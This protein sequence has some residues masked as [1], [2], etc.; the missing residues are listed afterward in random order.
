MVDRFAALSGDHSSLHVDA[1]FARRSPYRHRVVHGMLPV[2]YLG[3]AIRNIMGPDARPV[4]ITAQFLKPVFPETHLEMILVEQ[5]VDDDTSDPLKTFEYTIVAAAA[6]EVITSG[7]IKAIPDTPS[8]LEISKDH[9]TPS[10][11]IVGEVL[12]E[13]R[14]DFF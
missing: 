4:E 8:D 9:K 6:G 10:S 3:P 2:M 13:T 12:E 7:S 14:R 11:S 1:G 5:P